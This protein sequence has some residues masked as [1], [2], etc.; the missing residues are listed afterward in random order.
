MRTELWR[1]PGRSRAPKVHRQ[2]ISPAVISQ[3]KGQSRAVIEINDRRL[4]FVFLS[5]RFFGG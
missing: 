2:G 3:A 5:R 4:C 1:A